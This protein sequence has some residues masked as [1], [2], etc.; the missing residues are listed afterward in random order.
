MQ[1]VN[2]LRGTQPPQGPHSTSAVLCAEYVEHKVESFIHY[3]SQTKDCFGGLI[4]LPKLN[5]VFKQK[6]PKFTNLVN[7]DL[8]TPI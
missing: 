4:K 3:K 8:F 1:S 7:C 2:I 6:T 5:V